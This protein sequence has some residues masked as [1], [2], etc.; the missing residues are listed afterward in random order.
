[1][2][3]GFKLEE[4]DIATANDNMGFE[5]MFS[6][7]RYLILS[8]I[9][10]TQVI[11]LCII[12]SKYKIGFHSDEVWNYAFAN[13]YETKELNVSNAGESLMNQWV[14]AEFFLHYISVD[15]EHRFN[16]AQVIRNSSMDQN[17]PLQYM[18]LHTICSFFPGK[19]SWYF[20]FGLNLVAFVI[21]QFYLFRLTEQITK[22]TLVAFAT[23]ILY[24]FGTGAMDIAIFLRIYALGVMFMVIFSYYSHMIY[25]SSKERKYAIKYYIGMG[26]SC[27]LGAYT[28]HLFLLIAFILT[29]FYIVYYLIAKRFRAFFEHGLICLSGALLSIVAFPS[30]FSHLLGP[31]EA[32]NYSFVKYPTPM[33]I[34]LYF[35]ELT[36]D[37][38]GLHVSPLPNPYL[39]WFLIAL[40]CTVV[41]VTPFIFVF[42]KDE[43][44]KKLIIA[45]KTCFKRIGYK[46]KN[47]SVT[48]LA[49]LI[50]TIAMIIIAAD[51]T[52]VY[53][54]TVFCNRY[55]FLVYPLAVIFVASTIYYLVYLLSNR[56]KPAVV[57]TICICLIFAVWSHMLN[58]SWD[59]LLDEPKE[60]KICEDFEAESNTVIVLNE[61]W[62]LT[63]FAPKLC[64]TNSYYATNFRDKVE[65]I[66]F[67][68]I[69]KEA[70]CYLVVDRMP[71]LD[72][73][74]SYEEL[75]NDVVFSGWA[76]T[77][78][79]EDDFLKQYLELPEVKDIKRRGTEVMMNREFW[80]YEVEF[81]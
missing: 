66:L 74:I 8:I 80:I 35:Y 12:F 16:Y 64:Y 53:L 11:F 43:W 34:R 2:K 26:V 19:F 47:I 55:L 52:S 62:T 69:D 44:F 57:V 6:K 61:D 18:I 46:V 22:K 79:H 38:F 65:F 24:G 15:K 67:E 3:T 37:L 42:K 23:L 71:I 40:G 45:L 63:L 68:D 17:P 77:A 51:R 1:L 4:S 50:A 70:P 58:N 81:E 20:C 5:K 33:Q 7:K 29:V 54:M 30:I 36:K 21:T 14:D 60:G 13:S 39:E 72:S 31:K 28:M 27:F 41:I 76:G 49:Y 73:E 48:L 56:Q 9:I 78:K 32:H 75:E 25:E 10:L 59:Y